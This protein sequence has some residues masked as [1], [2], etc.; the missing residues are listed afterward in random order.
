MRSSF[1]LVASLLLLATFLGCIETDVL[2]PQDEVV[3]KPD[4][5]DFGFEG[6]W[7]NTDMEVGMANQKIEI[8]KIRNGEYELLSDR[9]DDY[10]MKLVATEL[11]PETKVAIVEVV[12]RADKRPYGRYLFLAKR[13]N[14]HLVVSMIHGKEI[15]KLMHGLGHSGVI[16]RGGMTTKVY[17]R[18]EA[19]LDTIRKHASQLMDNTNKFKRIEP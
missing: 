12:V 11:T 8:K 17:A 1:F 18:S 2:Q 9:F 7:L 3:T 5:I 10:Q 13:E 15:A 6:L 4:D 14:D 16:E 19:I